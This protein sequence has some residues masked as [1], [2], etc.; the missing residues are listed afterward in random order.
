LLIHSVPQLRGEFPEAAYYLAVMRGLGIH[1]G[2]DGIVREEEE[3]KRTAD[4][5]DVEGESV[6]CCFAVAPGLVFDVVLDSIYSFALA[7]LTLPGKSHQIS[8]SHSPTATTNARTLA[9]CRLEWD[10]DDRSSV[11]E[12]SH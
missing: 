5:G 7:C 3:R 10:A 1:G 2:G 6:V 9:W 8:A 12:Q 4:E 11:Q